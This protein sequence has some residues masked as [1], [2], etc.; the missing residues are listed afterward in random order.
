MQQHCGSRWNR[1]SCQGTCKLSMA[2]GMCLPTGTDYMHAPIAPSTVVGNPYLHSRRALYCSVLRYSMRTEYDPCLSYLYSEETWGGHCSQLCQNR[3]QA[4]QACELPSPATPGTFRR[5]TSWHPPLSA[6][7]EDQVL[8]TCT[9]RL[10]G[11]RAIGRASVIAK[12]A[13]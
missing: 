11:R 2:S 7:R 12:S 4:C 9:R 8:C 1:L 5:A 10:Q 3:A 6:L 13:L